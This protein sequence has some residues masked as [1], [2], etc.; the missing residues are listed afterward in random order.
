MIDAEP[1]AERVEAKS[2]GEFGLRIALTVT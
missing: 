1:Q 2:H